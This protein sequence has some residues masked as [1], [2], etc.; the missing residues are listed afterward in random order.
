MTRGVRGLPAMELDARRN[1]VGIGGAIAERRIDL[2]PGHDALIHEGTDGVSFGD[3]K[4]V[5][6][7]G[8]LPDIRAAEQP[9]ATTGWPIP[10]GDEGM[11]IVA[12]AFL[13][14]AAKTIGQCLAGSPCAHSKA[15]GQSLVQ[16]DGHVDRHV[17][18]VAHCQQRRQKAKSRMGYKARQALRSS[19]VHAAPHSCLQI[20]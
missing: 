2:R 13:G 16:P 12:S 7:H 11:L 19:D 4:V 15:L 20:S 14:I 10:E 8:D 6:P 18:N 3:R 9:G 17:C 1:L 5:D